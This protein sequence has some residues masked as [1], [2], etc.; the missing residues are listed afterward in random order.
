VK[1]SLLFTVISP[2]LVHWFSHIVFC[3]F[4]DWRVLFRRI[5]RDVNTAMQLQAYECSGIISSFS[6]C[7]ENV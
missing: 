2:H 3:F 7:D 1:E 5:L 4:F 6:V